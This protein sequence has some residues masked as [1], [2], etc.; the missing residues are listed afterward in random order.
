[1]CFRHGNHETVAPD[2][3]GVKI[4]DF[5][6]AGHEGHVKPVLTHLYLCLAGR[7]FGDAKVYLGMKTAKAIKQSL[8]KSANDKTVDT[9]A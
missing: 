4:G 2:H 9:D 8:E 7:A 1:M 3:A 5:L 6:G